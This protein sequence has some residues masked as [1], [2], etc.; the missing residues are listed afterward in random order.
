M[1][2][3]LEVPVKVEAVHKLSSDLKYVGMLL[4]GDIPYRVSGRV[5]KDRFVGYGMGD[6]SRD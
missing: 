4:A 3:S 1:S 5:K 6:T 2:V